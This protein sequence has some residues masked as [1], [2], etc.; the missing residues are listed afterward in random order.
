MGHISSS[1]LS[2]KAGNSKVGGGGGGVWLLLSPLLLL[3]L[4]PRWGAEMR[5][6][7]SLTNGAINL[8]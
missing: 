8:P 6:I 5:L 2:L 4:L 1:T 3:L 7:L